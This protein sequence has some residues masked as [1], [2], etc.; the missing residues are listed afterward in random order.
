MSIHKKR[1]YLKAYIEQM[2]HFSPLVLSLDGVMVEEKKA[3]TK[4]LGTH[5]SNKWYQAY[6]VT[7]DYVRY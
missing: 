1:N 7:C 3:D 2:L 4:Q 6:L 5:L